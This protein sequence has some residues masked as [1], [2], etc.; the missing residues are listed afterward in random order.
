MLIVGSFSGDAQ[1]VDKV[2]RG[3]ADVAGDRLAGGGRVAGAQSG[4]GGPVPV[5][6]MGEMPRPVQREVDQRP[7]AHPH[8]LD[9]AEEDRPTRSGVDEGVKA[10]VVLEM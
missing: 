9:Q 5:H 6:G 1:D 10:P 8:A 4:L 3:D 2:A 7:D